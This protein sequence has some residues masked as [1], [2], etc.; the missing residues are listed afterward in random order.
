MPAKFIDGMKE[1][2]A[3]MAFCIQEFHENR[4]FNFVFVISC[5][6]HVKTHTSHTQNALRIWR[7]KGNKAK[8]S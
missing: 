6:E 8:N 4:H 2:Y 7:T 1:A 5:A 3:V